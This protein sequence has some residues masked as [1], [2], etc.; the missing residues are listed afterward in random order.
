MRKVIFTA[1]F[2]A[3]VC[4]AAR[5]DAAVAYVNSW[6]NHALASSVTVTTAPTTNDLEVA[7]LYTYNSTACAT[8]TVPTGWSLQGGPTC[9]SSRNK[10]YV[11]TRTAAGDTSVQFTVSTSS[12][13]DAYVYDVSGANTSSPID[14]ISASAMVTSTTPSAP[15]FTANQA[16][17]FAIS[18]FGNGYGAAT[19]SSVTAGWTQLD[20][21]WSIYHTNAYQ[22]I[23][24]SGAVTGP[25]VAYAV[26]P[27]S[28][29]V[30]TV[31]ITPAVSS[32]F[33]S[34]SSMLAGGPHA[35]IPQ[36]GGGVTVAPMAP[37][38][39]YAQSN[40]NCG[41]GY[42][43]FDSTAAQDVFVGIE[44]CTGD[45]EQSTMDAKCPTSS[46]CRT[47]NY[48]SPTQIDCGS[49]Y[50][51]A[52]YS[53]LFGTPGSGDVN[54]THTATPFSSANRATTS[55][56]HCDTSGGATGT[57]MYYPN[58]AQ[59]GVTS[60]L[61][62]TYFASGT[63]AWL[64][65]SLWKSMFLDNHSFLP[66]TNAYGVTTNEFPTVAS[67]RT[68][69][70]T[71][72]NALAP[73][74][75][76]IN[77][78]GPGSG[79]FPHNNGTGS[80]VG[81]INWA[82]DDT[83]I[84]DNLTS[85]ERSN[86]RGFLF[87]KLLGNT[88][89]VNATASDYL[90]P[91]NIKTA[92]NTASIHWNDAN[93]APINLLISGMTGQSSTTSWP[94]R[95]FGVVLRGL[96][97]PT[98]YDGQARTPGI[99]MGPRFSSNISATDRQAVFPEDEL[100]MTQPLVALT[101][102]CW[103]GGSCSGNGQSNADTFGGGC[104]SSNGDTGGITLEAQLCGTIGTGPDGGTAAAYVREFAHC[105]RLQA[106]LGPCAVVFNNSTSTNI[107]ISQLT[108]A[109]TY[110]YELVPTANELYDDPVT[111]G[112]PVCSSATLCT[113]AWA[114]SPIT[115]STVIGHC[116]VINPGSNNAVI[117][118]MNSANATCARILLSQ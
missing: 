117:D 75:I 44:Y 33:N 52:F 36:G 60:Y 107:T 2:L 115:T 40:P 89:T 109:H 116:T 67:W 15:G 93:C 18:S 118:A 8:L 86:V 96:M 31:A 102:W 59:S 19:A 13:L 38:Y 65:G 76:L 111:T 6:K 53:Y 49:S 64:N 80:G 56:G 70:A 82:I 73:Y 5:A 43:G 16:G 17:D 21:N 99:V 58:I 1:L 62:S 3:F 20:D 104:Y 28:G 106:D 101:K 47:Y 57:L 83:D 10:T 110:T 48:I 51:S 108:L 69:L 39:T 7:V 34:L 84:C 113:G 103:G 35:S 114:E 92:V 100:N 45:T 81:I 68:A 85:A 98:G 71:E 27:T 46:T 42:N 9:T 26:A 63:T 37:I 30:L 87:E 22:A 105:F 72:M 23:A 4:A 97:T 91:A 112:H 74:S 14:A 66:I 55:A 90:W 25:S 32:L 79:S 29:Q 95:A 54:F 77:S 41:G 61:V 78:E 88:G 94:Q 50:Q 12:Y 11:L 24:G